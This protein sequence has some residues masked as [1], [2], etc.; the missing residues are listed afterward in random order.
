MYSYDQEYGGDADGFANCNHIENPMDP[1]KC[2][3]P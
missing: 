2:A 3:P 1:Y